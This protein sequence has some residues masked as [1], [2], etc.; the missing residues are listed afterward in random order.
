M[1][2]IEASFSALKSKKQ[3]AYIGYVMAGF[4][5]EAASF[6]LAQGLLQAGADL[7]EIGVP[8]SDPIADGVVIQRCG[9]LA[10]AS[11]ASLAMALK[12]A[13]RLR[14]SSPKPLL[15]MSYL[16]PIL[17]KG[18]EAFASEAKAS[19]VDGFVI[20]D[21]TPEE[22]GPL[23][24]IFKASGLDI[25]FLAAPT[26]TPARLKKIAA[27][28]SGFIYMVSV[29]GVTGERSGFDARLGNALAQLRKA[30]HLPVAVGFGVSSPETAAQAAAQGDG[31]VVASTVLKLL[32]DGQ[33]VGAA[34]EKARGLIEAAH[35]A[36]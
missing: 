9:E 11:G 20:P 13:K 28:A 32:L 6:E 15:L 36:A 26:S 5:D 21:L 17:A 18:A 2:R 3:K 24:K 4:P 23:S 34:V 7:L 8:F 16:N 19:G 14:E 25:V 27:A 10:L 12:L 35:S 1:S 22:A 31:V 30:T 33:S 29:A